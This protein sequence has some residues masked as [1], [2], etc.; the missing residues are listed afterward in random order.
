MRR[1]GVACASSSSSKNRPALRPE[2][3]SL[4]PALDVLAR[5]RRPV[6]LAGLGVL[7]GRASA[8]L[9][10]FAE[11]LGAPVLTSTK[12]KG[13]IPEDH[14]LRAGVLI[15]GVI[16]RDMVNQADLIVAVGLDGVELQPKPWTY[17]QPVL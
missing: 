9:V 17:S 8:G 11:Q 15:G 14:P 6:I 13:V 7:W 5:A 10:A 16:E 1:V 2:R 4:K 3:A 12:A